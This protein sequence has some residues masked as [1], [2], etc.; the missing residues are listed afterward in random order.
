[1][2]QLALGYLFWKMG[3][4]WLVQYSLSDFSL[5]SLTR[6]TEIQPCS[7]KGVAYEEANKEIE[8]VGT[9]ADISTAAK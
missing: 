5:Y 2:P 1:M 9:H 6:A 8:G 4:T 3:L 7:K